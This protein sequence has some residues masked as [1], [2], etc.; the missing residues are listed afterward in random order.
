MRDIRR[1][2][3][4]GLSARPLQVEDTSV[5]LRLGFPVSRLPL[6]GVQVSARLQTAAEVPLADITGV[7]VLLGDLI[8]GEGEVGEV[9]AKSRSLFRT[10]S[11]A[12]S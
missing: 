11:L 10:Y 12:S 5:R 4:G 3:G 8:E 2:R 9:A 6:R 1:Y 7:E